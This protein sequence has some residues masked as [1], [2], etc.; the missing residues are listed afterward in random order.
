MQ[1][2]NMQRY[3]T[4]LSEAMIF[5]STLIFIVQIDKGEESLLQYYRKSRKSL[6][7]QLK[8][9]LEE[10]IT[11]YLKLCFPSVLAFLKEKQSLV[12]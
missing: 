5:S 6:I 4:P 2:C 8:E 9:R 10:E 7:E 11:S 1:C 3:E 12:Y